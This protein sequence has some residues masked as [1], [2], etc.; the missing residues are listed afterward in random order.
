MSQDKIDSLDALEIAIKKDWD[1]ECMEKYDIAVSYF[2]CAVDHAR[3]SIRDE[4]IAKAKIEK[5]KWKD[6]KDKFGVGVH[7][8]I[9]ALEFVL[10][11]E[12]I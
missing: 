11:R 3:R 4:V 8:G 7:A 9:E 10:L 12:D 6:H 2:N 5:D 1:I